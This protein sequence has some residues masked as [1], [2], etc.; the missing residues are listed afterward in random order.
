LSTSTRFL[1]RNVIGKRKEIAIFERA[2]VENHCLDAI[3]EPALRNALQRPHFH[4]WIRTRIEDHSDELSPG[5]SG[6]CSAHQKMLMM[7]TSC[8]IPPTMMSFD[9]RTAMKNLNLKGNISEEN[10]TPV[11]LPKRHAQKVGDTTISGRSGSR[12]SRRS[13]EMRPNSKHHCGRHQFLS[14]RR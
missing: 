14:R 9:L 11:P 7:V 8:V 3:H 12:R 10:A 1:I 13:H 2:C 5:R 6:L 4:N